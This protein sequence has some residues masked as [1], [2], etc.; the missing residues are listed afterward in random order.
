MQSREEYTRVRQPT[1]ARHAVRFPVLFTLF[2]VFVCTAA[3]P[4]HVELD[5][6][7]TVNEHI[8]Y[9][10]RLHGTMSIECDTFCNGEHLSRVTDCTPLLGNDVEMNPGRLKL[11][12][13]QTNQQEDKRS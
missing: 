3:H 5:I 2:N 11:P 10:F 4:C 13:H 1:G 9:K 6:N 12:P 7:N 8:S